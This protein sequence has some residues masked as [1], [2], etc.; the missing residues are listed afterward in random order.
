MES[1]YVG[2]E[3]DLQSLLL[4]KHSKEGDIAICEDTRKVYQ[5]VNG[6]WEPMKMS[7]GLEMSLYEMNKQIIAQLPPYDDRD[8]L[9]LRKRINK[10][11][12]KLYNSYYMLLCKDFN[13]Y[14]IFA[15]NEADAGEF[16]TIG[17]AV[18]AII[19]E[20]NAQVYSADNMED[21]F[22][23]WLKPEGEE[24]IYDFLFFP[25]DEGVVEFND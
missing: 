15:H 23:I 7:G 3:K 6:E 18:V 1:K 9:K 5:Y 20:M 21:R 4:K 10:F 12:E 14:T 22:E 16:K 13:Y 19:K 17:H 25:Y 8:L 24:E 2:S 11:T